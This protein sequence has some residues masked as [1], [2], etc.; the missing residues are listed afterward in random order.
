M[1]WRTNENV[2][3]RGPN[4]DN[5][6]KKRR[7]KEIGKPKKATTTTKKTRPIKKESCSEKKI[8]GEKNKTKEKRNGGRARFGGA[9]WSPYR[10]PWKRQLGARN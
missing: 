5:N 9:H 4:D 10:E 8:D 7:E 6:K 3:G 1:T 2:G